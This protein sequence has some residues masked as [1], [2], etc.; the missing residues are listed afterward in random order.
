MEKKKNDFPGI[1]KAHGW[2]LSEMYVYAIENTEGKLYVGLT[3]SLIR[4][5]RQHRSGKT[6]S[7][8]KGCLQ[9][10]LQWFWNC[11]DYADAA[12]LEK[13]LHKKSKEGIIQV[14]MNPDLVPDLIDSIP[15]TKF[16]LMTDRQRNWVMEGRGD[17]FEAGIV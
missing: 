16:D 7:T 4:R 6:R 12:R 9:W 3:N 13:A 11:K 15:L 1:M 17:P 5:I 10:E 2:A 8:N 14:I